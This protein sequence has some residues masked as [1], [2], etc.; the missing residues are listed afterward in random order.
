MSLNCEEIDHILAEEPLD[1]AK[2]Q[3]IFQPS[4]DSIVLELYKHQKAFF[5]L[6]SIAHSACRLHP[7]STSPHRNDRPLRF[8][9]CLRARIRGGTILSARQFGKDRIVDFAIIRSG[10]DGAPHRIHLYARLWSGAGNVLLVGE[11]GVV[12]DA[13]RRLP[14][15]GEVSGAIFTMPATQS[16]S[17]NPQHRYALREIPGE[18]PFWKKIEQF[19]AAH[20]GHLSL[21][22]LQSQLRELYG[23]KMQSMKHR[24]S[25]LE[26]KLNEYALGERY[27]QIGDILLSGYIKKTEGTTTFAEAYDFYQQ[28]NLLVQIDPHLD[29]AK[30]AAIYYEKYRKARDGKAELESEIARLQAS[31]ARFEQWYQRQ[32]AE[33]DPLML[34]KALKKGGT[35]RTRQKEPFPC[36]HVEY[37]GWIILVGRSDKENDELLRH[38]VKGSDLWLHARDYPGSYVFIKAIKNKSFPPE[39]LNA[40]ARLA[41]YYSKARK[42][43]AGDV[44]VTQVKNLRRVKNGPIGLVIPYLEKNLYIKFTE[45]QIRDILSEHSGEEEQI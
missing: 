28:K 18:G 29:P 37:R 5:Y 16:V 40:A 13:L 7:L 10:D 33:T 11:N 41:L 24:L 15:R 22:A 14:S 44:H 31:I 30:N 9:E 32:S 43:G 36:L 45:S 25:A 21:D 3:N 1:G 20:S 8:M 12:I 35:V 26:S 17:G 27:R 4:F 42:N 34:A 19:Y 39:I 38:V 6:I 2:I 23:R